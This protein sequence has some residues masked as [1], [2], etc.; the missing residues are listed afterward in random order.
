MPLG[1]VLKQ[2]LHRPRRKLARQVLA[3][4]LKKPNTQRQKGHVAAASLS[5]GKPTLNQSQDRAAAS[6]R[7][8]IG[9]LS[10]LATLCV[11][12]VRHSIDLPSSSQENQISPLV[13]QSPQECRSESQ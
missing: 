2:R 3:V 7:G 10:R 13:S 1:R 8:G 9:N 5:S 12:W 4:H 11:A 6:L